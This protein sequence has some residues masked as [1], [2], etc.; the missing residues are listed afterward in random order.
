MMALPWV[1]FLCCLS[2]FNLGR[3]K[4]NVSYGQGVPFQSLFIILLYINFKKFL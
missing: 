4:A 1:R 2:F 3:M